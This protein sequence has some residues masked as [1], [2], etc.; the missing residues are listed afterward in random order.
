MLLYRARENLKKNK[1][2]FVYNFKEYKGG[3]DLDGRI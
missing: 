1:K 2:L 3:E